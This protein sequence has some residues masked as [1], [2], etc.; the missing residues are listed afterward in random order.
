[1]SEDDNKVDLSQLT[2]IKW[3]TVVESG[4]P[5]P[6][7]SGIGGVGFKKGNVPFERFNEIVQEMG[8]GIT[9]SLNSALSMMGEVATKLNNMSDVNERIIAEYLLRAMAW[10]Y[11]I[12]HK[13]PLFLFSPGEFPNELL[14]DSEAE[15]VSDAYNTNVGKKGFELVKKGGK[16][17]Y[18]RKK[19]K[20][21]KRS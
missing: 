21:K 12:K 16:K 3:E 10:N 5:I 13:V 7:V 1:M 17:K 9:N 19:G 20:S 4:V 6:V 15:N 8:E 11:A 18:V 2:E 14:V